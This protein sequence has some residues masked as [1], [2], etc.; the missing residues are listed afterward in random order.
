[1]AVTDTG[2]KQEGA[3][4]GPARVLYAPTTVAVPAGLDSI[5]NLVADVNGVYAPKT[6]WVDFG[7]AADASSYSKGHDTEGQEYEQ[8]TGLLFEQVSDI[9]RQIT[10]NMA[11]ILPENLQIIESSGVISTKAAAANVSAQQVLKAGSF[12]SVTRY[13]IAI[14]SQRDVG[15]V[16][17]T[18]PGGLERGGL[19][20]QVG[21]ACALS[22]DDSEL[23]S[24]AGDPISADV[25]FTLFPETGQPKGQEYVHHYL[26]QAGVISAV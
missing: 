13:R 25:Q 12:T 22:G 21:L 10:V 7:L 6:G 23:S 17:V 16:K 24:G 14:I 4:S 8:P 9:N 19:V 18:E 1:M 2:Y 26:E 3:V 15:A 5:I 11:E 20:A